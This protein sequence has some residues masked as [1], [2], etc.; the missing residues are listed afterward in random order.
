MPVA[1]LSNAVKLGPGS[2][3]R[4]RASVNR[5]CRLID[6]RPSNTSFR[7]PLDLGVNTEPE[8]FSHHL[9]DA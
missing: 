2:D 9:F 7:R 4:A 6:H 8:R 3:S 5:D 1:I